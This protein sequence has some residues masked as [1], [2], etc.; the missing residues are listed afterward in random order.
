MAAAPSYSEDLFTDDAIVRPY[1]RYRELRELGPVVWL[2]AHQMYVLPRYAEAR[3]VLADPDMFCSGRGVGLNDVVNTVGVGTTLMSDG[4]VHDLQRAVLA[5]RLTPRGLRPLHQTVQAAADALVERLVRRGSFDAVRDLARALPLSIVPDLVGWPLRGRDH[6]LDWS[7][8][9]FD[10][11]GP[12]NARAE[13]AV[14]SIQAMLE[15]AARTVADRDVIVGSAAADMLG[16]VD[17]GKLTDSQAASL[18]ID[19]LGPSLDTT[20]SAIGSGVWLFG[21][22][23]DQ[24]Q[25]LRAQPELLSNA[26]NEIIRLESPIRGFTRLVTTDTVIA[27]HEVPAEAR[28]LVLFASANRDELRWPD[29]DLFD[30][31][32]NANGQIGFGYGTHGCAGQGLA[33]LEGHAVLR[34]LMERV[35]IF[36]LG[37]Q[38]W[39]VNNIIHALATLE[40]SVCPVSRSAGAAVTSQ[41]DRPS[42]RPAP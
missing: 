26:F 37:A 13:R 19:Y 6:L 9:T 34:A 22:H 41:A 15:F 21:R 11:L 39:A 29:A 3:A 14:P 1:G 32:R 30:I 35:E 38:T 10:I 12:M 17:E 8:A 4:E 7:A 24:W 31:T 33:R 28:L 27:G 40:V 42:R 20:I 2:E 23:P 18:I 5:R 16:A 25:L 36:E